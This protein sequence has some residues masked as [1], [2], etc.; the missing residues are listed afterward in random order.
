MEL[1]PAIFR[2]ILA[3]HPQKPLADALGVTPGTVC[4][5][6]NASRE[7]GLA[8]ALRALKALGYVV[9]V[10]AGEADNPDL[11]RR[12]DRAALAVRRAAGA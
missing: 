9:T 8:D 11:S 5:W 1:S 12:I 2:S 10:A 7:P 3:E 6:T 4:R